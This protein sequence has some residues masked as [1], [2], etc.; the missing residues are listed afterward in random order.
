PSIR[1]AAASSSLLAATNLKPSPGLYDPS[2]LVSGNVAS[3][4]SEPGPPPRRPSVRLA[5]PP[6]PR[7]R[8]A[9]VRR[10]H[11]AFEDDAFENGPLSNECA[12][13]GLLCYLAGF[14]SVCD[15]Q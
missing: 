15:A 2:T 4:R 3:W 13:T 9:A 10:C 5:Q 7:G 12:A 1:S 14:G 11:P 8:P 6:R